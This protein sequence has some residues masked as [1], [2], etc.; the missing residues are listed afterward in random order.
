MS[1][2]SF[3][4]S[5]SLSVSLS[6]SLSFLAQRFSC[7]G[8][9][10]LLS[11]NAGQN[12]WKSDKIQIQTQYKVRLKFE[13][14]KKVGERPRVSDWMKEKMEREKKTHIFSV[15]TFFIE[16]KKRRRS[17]QAMRI[18]FRFNRICVKIKDSL[19]LPYTSIQLIA[20]LNILSEISISHSRCFAMKARPYNW[21][22][23]THSADM[24]CVCVCAFFF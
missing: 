13:W 21:K 17:S 5:L 16:Y 12:S 6:L 2:F 3:S 11:Q 19:H 18:S 22:F 4:L 23:R 20:T 24:R 8:T 15:Y 14:A 9:V 10:M 1:S 7:R